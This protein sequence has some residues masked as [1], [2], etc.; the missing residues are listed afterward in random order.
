[1]R[2]QMDGTQI[3]RLNLKFIYFL[4]IQKYAWVSHRVIW[5]VCNKRV[6]FKSPFLSFFFNF[7]P[8]L[9]DTLE[10]REKKY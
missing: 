4:Q 6:I 5:A 3:F 7:Y 9:D 8:I 1:M 10:S 2:I